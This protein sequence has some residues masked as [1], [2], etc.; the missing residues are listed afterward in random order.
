M[1][2]LPIEIFNHILSYRPAHDTALCIHE[3]IHCYNNE[4]GWLYTHS[5][6]IRKSDGTWHM[7]KYYNFCECNLNMSF[8]EYC[9]WKRV[10]D[11]DAWNDVYLHPNY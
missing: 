3:L 2:T 9:F 10:E 7:K 4:S 1:T 8:Q 5:R 11:C 6:S